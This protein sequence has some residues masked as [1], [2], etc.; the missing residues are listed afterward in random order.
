MDNG[1]FSSTIYV[2]QVVQYVFQMVM[3]HTPG[4][5][6]TWP[7][8]WGSNTYSNNS[9]SFNPICFNHFHPWITINMLMLR[10]WCFAYHG[11]ILWNPLKKSTKRISARPGCGGVS[12]AICSTAASPA[13]PVA[14]LSASSG[15]PQL[16]ATWLDLWELEF[17]QQNIGTGL[18]NQQKNTKI[19]GSIISI[20]MLDYVTLPKQCVLTFNQQTNNI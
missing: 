9:S 4:E 8:S 11:G 16:W 17:H 1:P 3:F 13:G 19:T 6:A 2:L 15:A 10:F 5:V 20:A 14:Q 12:F 7:Y 18:Q